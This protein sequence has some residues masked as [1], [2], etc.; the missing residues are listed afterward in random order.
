MVYRKKRSYGSRWTFKRAG[1]R[2]LAP[3]VRIRRAARISKIGKIHRFKRTFFNSL[4]VDSTG[5][6]SFFN[7]ANANTTPSSAGAHLL[8]NLPQFTEFT[9]LFDQYK[10]TG[11][12]AK[13]IFT[14]N[15]ADLGTAYE[16]PQLITVNDFD[17]GNTLTVRDD[18]CQYESFKVTR[19]DK[20][21]TIFYKPKVAT[22]I[23]NGAFT[24]YAQA[25]TA[26]WIDVATPGAQ[27]YGLKWAVDCTDAAAVHLGTLDVYFT[28]YLAFRDVR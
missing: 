12:K 11:V 27:Y 25:G 1:W 17:D 8:N 5:L 2:R 15:N 24:G 26:P 22:A 4:Q 18:Y 14:R 19:L 7:F 13:F 6:V 16:L 28:Y 20:P 3:G 21:V 23:F 10:I 9:T